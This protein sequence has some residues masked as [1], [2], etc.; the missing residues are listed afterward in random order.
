MTTTTPRR[1]ESPVKNNP[2]LVVRFGDFNAKSNNWCEHYITTSEGK[3]IE[4]ISSQFGFHHVINEPTHIL[5]SSS[6]CI[7]LIFTSQPNFIIESGVH[8]SFYPNSHHQ[9]I[10][11]KSGLEIIFPPPYFRD[12]WHLICLQLICLIET[13]LS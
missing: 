13:E 1:H 3:G 4:N 7:D 5:E 6:S 8:P 2:F 12:V 10:F 9:I 11:V